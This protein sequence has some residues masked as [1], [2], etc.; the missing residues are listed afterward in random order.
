MKYRRRAEVRRSF[1]T[2]DLPRLTSTHLLGCLSFI[3]AKSE[4]EDNWLPVAGELQPRRR[5]GRR[6]GAVPVRHGPPSPLTRRAK[7]NVI[8]LLR[9][10]VVV[11][12]HQ[13]RTHA[14]GHHLLDLL[15][16]HLVIHLAS[17]WCPLSLPG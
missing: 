16:D 17:G 11:P 3:I 4:P 12:R 15:G 8:V 7:P 1:I 13:Q 9:P 6:V 2:S 10:G 5:P 14:G